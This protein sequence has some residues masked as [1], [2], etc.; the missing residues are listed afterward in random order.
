[1]KQ[2]TLEKCEWRL[3]LQ[4]LSDRCLTAE[5]IEIARRLHPDLTEEQV[6]DRWA[7]VEPLRVLIHQGYV[8]PL[9][10]L[11]DLTS[12][13]RAIE[14][15]QT[16]SGR[17]LRSI[18]QLLLLTKNIHKFAQDFGQKCP[19]LKS[20]HARI[21]PLPRIMA[22]IERTVAADGELLDNASPE[23]SRI[24]SAKL[25]LRKKIE[26]HIKQ[27]FTDPET[28]KYLQDEF[29]TIRSDRYVVPIAL[30]GRG[31]IK[32]AIYDTSDSGQ[33]LYIEP[34]SIA[35][36]NEEFLELEVGEKLEILRIFREIGQKLKSDLDHLRIDYQEIVRLDFLTAMAKQAAILDARPIQLA[37]EPGLSLRQARHPVLVLQRHRERDQRKVIACDVNLEPGQFCLMISGPNAGGKTVV[38]KT[39]GLIHIMAKAGLL[40][41]ASE[42]SS[43]FLFEDIFLELGDAQNLGAN[44][45]TFSGHMMG[46]KPIIEKATRQDL[47]LLDE[48]AAGTEPLAGAAIAQAI[49]ED[50]VAKQS[51][52]VV[53]THYDAL[54]SLALQRQDF[55]NAS[56]EYADLRPTYHVM[57]DIPG[58]SYGIEMAS[59]LGIKAAIVERAKTLRGNQ[60]NRLDD[61]LAELG[62]LRRDLT[63]KNQELV[64]K[65]MELESSRLHWEQEKHALEETR[66]NVSSQ[67]RQQYE[68]ELTALRQEFDETLQSLKSRMKNLDD[69]DHKKEVL[70]LRQKA[71]QKIKQMNASVQ[72]HAPTEAPRGEALELSDLQ[73]GAVV[74]VQGLGQKGTI[75]RIG[76]QNDIEVR[77]GALSLRVELKDLA[78]A[79]EKNIVKK[80]SVVASRKPPISPRDV[81]FTPK[82]S[83]NSLDLRG[84]DL[85]SAIDLTM[86]FIDQCFRRGEMQLVIIHGHGSN[87]LKMGIR[88]A[89]QDCRDYDLGFRPGEDTEGGDGVTIVL[90]QT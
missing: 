63:L 60:A 41:P 16:L 11:D 53:T 15:Q 7:Q 25:S 36:M 51:I 34:S 59:Q 23:L 68:E 3:I 74:M 55:R 83:S 90:V 50:M 27:L 46:L 24:R 13:M 82:T 45:S 88:Q 49:L 62:Q 64:A 30:D 76:G 70:E 69:D 61:T 56:M 48:I 86:R 31:R 18:F 32:G 79:L 73:L 52:T 20:V 78:K 1:M 40:I 6:R 17:E 38:L 65:A 84:H 72:K 77:V 89:L 4:D 28:T 71:D 19:T 66:K 10:E 12:L 8:P 26:H 87:K 43:V 58:Q 33:T 42:E 21:Y 35:P 75:Q 44:L 5:G 80:P 2:N 9:A 85:D 14:L 57:L 54:K 67:L 81:P 39:V 47:V 22:E 37:R 29:F